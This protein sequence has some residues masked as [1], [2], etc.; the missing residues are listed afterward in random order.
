MDKWMQTVSTITGFILEQHPEIIQNIVQSQRAQ[1]SKQIVK[2]HDSTIA[3][4]PFKGFKFDPASS[5]GVD[6]RG[7]MILGLYEQEVLES[8]SNIDKS[9]KTFID[10]GAADGYYG[11]GVLVNSLFNK[12]YCFEISEVGQQV[13]NKHAIL[14]KVDERVSIMGEARGDFYKNIPPQDLRNS[15]LFVDIEGGEFELFDKNTFE[16]FK[17]SII[18]IELH[19]QFVIDGDN[20]L[21]KLK[22]DAQATH[23]VSEMSMSKRDLSKF[24]ELKTLS[25]TDRWMICSEGRPCLMSWMRLDPI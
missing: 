6:D 7:A 8:L 22:S 16:V 5:W 23:L 9:Y 17:N 19:N 14:N 11:I 4:G 3:Y 25:D 15:V 20:K 13:I 10:L 1:I 21:N 18:F 2:F 12:S 24:N